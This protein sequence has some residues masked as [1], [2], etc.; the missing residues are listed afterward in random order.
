MLITKMRDQSGEPVNS[1]EF[2][3]PHL[4]V[5]NTERLEDGTIIDGRFGL[6]SMMDYYNEAIE[7]GF[8]GVIIKD[9]NLSYEFGKRSKGWEKYKPA[10]VDIDVII[11]GATLGSGK[12]T[13]KGKTSAKAT[14][15]YP[16]AGASRFQKSGG[17]KYKA[18]VKKPSKPKPAPGK[19]GR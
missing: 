6:V 10:L 2:M 15:G 3:T 9:P 18:P 17:A 12:R 7:A 1:I 8:E 5:Y 13:G 16:A 11:T 19:G 14:R 4:I